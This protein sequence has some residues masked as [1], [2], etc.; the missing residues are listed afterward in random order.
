M[1]FPVRE[2][3]DCAAP[4]ELL[5][6]LGLDHGEVFGSEDFLVVVDTESQVR[7]LDP[8]FSRLLGLPRR[9]SNCYRTR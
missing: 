4:T 2:I 3:E 9:G 8:D 7:A 1:D 6:A 5:P